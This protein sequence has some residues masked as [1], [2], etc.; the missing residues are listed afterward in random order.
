MR[1]M[2]ILRM[3]SPRN[4][5]QCWIPWYQGVK[6][7]FSISIGNIMISNMSARYCLSPSEL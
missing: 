6:K 3:M 2:M 5:F 7:Y 4:V 1:S